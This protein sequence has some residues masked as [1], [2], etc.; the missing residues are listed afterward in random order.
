MRK[1]RFEQT[2]FLAILSEGETGLSVAEVC[3][4]HGISSAGVLSAEEQVRRHVGERTQARRG[5]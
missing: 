3:C 5:A 4:N 2:Q 1:S